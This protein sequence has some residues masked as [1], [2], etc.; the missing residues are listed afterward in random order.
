MQV[1]LIIRCLVQGKINCLL[2]LAIRTFNINIT[3]NIT[4]FTFAVISVLPIREQE[5]I[6][7]IHLTEHCI[8]G[9]SVFYSLPNFR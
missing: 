3:E 8:T 4:D 1:Y 9:L 7:R 5:H 6:I 2:V